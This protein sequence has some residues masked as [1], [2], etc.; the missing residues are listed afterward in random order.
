MCSKYIY[1]TLWLGN[2][3][4]G[5]GLATYTS[6][7]LHSSTRRTFW[8]QTL[9]VFDICSDIHFDSHMSL[10][11]P[12]VDTFV[13]GWPHLTRYNFC[14]RW[15]ILLKFGNLFAIR[16]CIVVP[17]F[18]YCLPELW[19]CIQGFTFFPGHSV[20]LSMCPFAFILQWL[21]RKIRVEIAPIRS[22]SGS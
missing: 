19:Q 7:S 5:A 12:I 8:T 4:K 16:H 22:F 3:E 1:K 17:E 13:L 21:W 18:C 6:S 9:V 2:V 11:V 10:R 20:Y 14:K 15:Q